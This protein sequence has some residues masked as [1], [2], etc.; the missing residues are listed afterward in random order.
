MLDG[1]DVTVIYNCSFVFPVCLWPS[2]TVGFQ[3]QYGQLELK[4]LES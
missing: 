4:R 3:M 2:N 1:L